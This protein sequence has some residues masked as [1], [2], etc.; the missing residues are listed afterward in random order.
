MLSLEEKRRVIAALDYDPDEG[1]V[2]KLVQRLK[3]SSELHQFVLNYNPNDGLLPLWSIIENPLCDQGTALCIYWLFA[4]VILDR[5]NY[6]EKADRDWNVK[7]LVSEIEHHYM[8]GFY[9]HHAIG[10]APMEYLDWSPTKLKLV[11]HQRGGDLPFPEIL[12]EPSP[13]EIVPKEFL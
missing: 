7:G 5:D 6:Q 4:D 9:T 8:S 1:N 3:T 13:G 12:L 10:F 2:V 11:R